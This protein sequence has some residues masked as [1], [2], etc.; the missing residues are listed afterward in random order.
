M[1]STLYEVLSV[2]NFH[3]RDTNIKFF[4]DGHK[5]CISMDPDVK[6]TS[7]TKW[8]DHHFP[9]FDADKVIENMMNGKGWKE[10]HKYWGKTTDQIKAQWNSNKDSLAG[11][12]TDL[13]H[14]IECFHNDK[15]IQFEYTNKELYEIYMSDKGKEL[16][17]TPIEW[18]YF[19]NFIK[20]HHHLKPYRTEWS[21]YHDD[22]KIAGSID[23]VYE[24]TDGTLSIYDWKRAKLITRINNFNRFAIHPLICHLPDSNFWHYALQLNTYKYILETK[25]EKKIKGLFLVRLHPDSEEKN[26]ELIELPDLSSEVHDLFQE[27]IKKLSS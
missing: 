6:Y 25:Y 5:Y 24:N 1:K 11:A 14:E 26:Y 17:N 4:E 15:R 2:R 9:K 12:G 22:A 8:N 19:I 20:E 16:E 7:V 13:H 21:V 3:S 23:M 18:Q 10:G 27:H